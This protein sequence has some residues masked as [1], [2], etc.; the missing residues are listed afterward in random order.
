MADRPLEGKVAI[1]TGAGSAIGMGRSMTLALVRAGARVAMTDIN[2]E[3]LERSAADAREIAG[4]DCVL[5]LVADVSEPADAERTVQQTIA[6]LGGLHIV[7]N[8]AGTNPRN[9]GL[10]TGQET[11]AWQVRP[12]AWTKVVAVN[13]SGPFFMIRAAVGHLLAQRWGRILGVTTSLD[14]M[15][16]KGAAPYGPSKAGHE[17]LMATI[18]QELEGT[19]VTANVLVPGGP[20]NTNLL[21]QDT[22]FDRA[23]LIQPDVMQ[24]PVV[25]LASDASDAINGKRFIAYHWDEALPLEQRLE[26]CSAPLAWPQLG[27]QAVY[28]GR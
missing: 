1:V 12:E 17:A 23:A 11:N 18:A 10:G 27:G 15:Y 9:V 2:P 13:F 6:G 14:T 22:P 5:S 25:W 20:V 19:G 3:A 7:V 26:K 8:N 16:R 21:G 24:R 4:R 28:P